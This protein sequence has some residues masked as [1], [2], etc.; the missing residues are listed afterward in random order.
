MLAD[1]QRAA[2]RLG[3]RAHDRVADRPDF[4][5][6]RLGQLRPVR[7]ALAQFV[8]AR[9]VPVLGLQSFDFALEVIGQRIPRRVLVG[10]QRVAALGRQLLRM[11][12][13]AQARRL[14]IGQVGMPEVAGVAQ[15]DR[16][17]VLLDIR[18]DE[19]LGLV[20][21]LEIAQ[22]VDLQGAEVAAEVH[23]LRGRDVLVA[24]HQHVIIEVRAVQPRKIGRGQRQRQVEADDFGAQW[25]A[26]KR[27]DGKGLA[28]RIEWH[29]DGV[30]E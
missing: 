14:F 9:Q 25:R 3:V 19:H 12:H 18:D 28:G 11:E 7:V 4:V 16:L 30:A 5:D 2:A 17:A 8:I 13:R 27:M 24:K 20:G 22:H 26:G 29:G 10:E 23:L 15:P 21:Q 6:L 1:E